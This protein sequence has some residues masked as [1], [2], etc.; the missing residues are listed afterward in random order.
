MHFPTPTWAT[1]RCRVLGP[2]QAFGSGAEPVGAECSGH[3]VCNDDG[4][5]V[6]ESTY[7]GLA[8]DKLIQALP[9]WMISRKQ[10]LLDLS[11]CLKGT[12][13][14]TIEVQCTDEYASTTGDEICTYNCP[15]L[16]AGDVDV[17]C[18]IFQAG[19]WH[20]TVDDTESIVAESS[21][22][23]ALSLNSATR[24]I[25]QGANAEAQCCHDHYQFDDPLTFLSED[26]ACAR[27]GQLSTSLA[28]TVTNDA[29]S[30]PVECDGSAATAECMSSYVCG[31][32]CATG[33]MV[34]PS[35]RLS[36]T[37][38]TVT[39][40]HLRF[41]DHNSDTTAS[42]AASFSLMES[43][44]NVEFGSFSRNTAGIYAEA[45]TVTVSFSTVDNGL[46]TGCC[47]TFGSAG[48]FATSHTTVHIDHSDFTN[49]EVRTCSADTTCAADPGEYVR[50][51]AL[52]CH[53]SAAVVTKSRFESNSGASAI[54][55]THQSELT[56]EYSTVSNNLVA[57]DGVHTGHC[58]G[59]VVSTGSVARI[60]F[61]MFHSNKGAVAGALFVHGTASMAF[62]E[63]SV[64][65]SNRA[66][67]SS[68]GSGAIASTSGGAVSVTSS[69]VDNNM[70]TTPVGAGAILAT[71]AAI[72]VTDSLLQNN[73]VQGNPDAISGSGGIYSDR[74]SIEVIR[75]KFVNNFGIR[76]GDVLAA[77]YSDALHSKSPEDVKVIDT[78]YDPFS[79]VESVIINPGS[80]NGRLRGACLDHPCHPGQECSYAD[81]S[82]SCAPCS[83]QTFSPDG[84][85]CIACD[86]GQG[87]SEDGT[88]C[89]PC[90]GDN[91]SA[92]GVCQPCSIQLVVSDD[93]RS[94]EECRVHQAATLVGDE[95][96]D[97]RKCGCETGFFNSST[98]NIACYYGGYDPDFASKTL[99]RQI[100]AAVST[101]QPCV[102]CVA[103][104]TGE[105][106]T[107]CQDGAD[108]AVRAGF[109]I[110]LLDDLST[111][112]QLSTSTTHEDGVTAIFR[113]HNDMELAAKRCPAGA[114][115]GTCALG[116]EG[117]MC[118]SCID[119]YGMNP[120]RECAPC[121][122]TGYTGQSMLVLLVVIVSVA[123]VGWLTGKIWSGF[124]LKHLA[125][126]A[127]QPARILITYSQ[128]TSQLGDVL[129]FQYPGIFGDVIGA[130]RPV[131]D[132]WGLLFRAL[133]PSECFGLK[134]FTA[135]W[136]L[137]VVGLPGMIALTII[138]MYCW[139]ARKH[140]AETAGTQ[141]KS[142]AFFGT[143]HRKHFP[144]L[145]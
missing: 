144:C 110:P 82:L 70:G 46:M 142:H 48:I 30:L 106:C 43:D 26:D 4:K 85:R 100:D 24:T 99:K 121:D 40:R 124:Q 33:G 65:H 83:R 51:T 58:A 71:D 137:R 81:F 120:S 3:G 123:A 21:V 47:S 92:F 109:T 2:G 18:Y 57:E 17:S 49:N 19:Q 87:P 6:C 141:A 64:F 118:D 61:A 80:Y 98:Q 10:A 115:P 130:L 94:C 107:S 131:M 105:P 8:C 39:L 42:D 29:A 38:A 31:F 53:E 16:S 36:L 113:C 27:G 41:E 28:T 135:R 23:N 44:V 77:D 13:V 127:F 56:L 138:S 22:F 132:L 104:A 126:C 68:A 114:A 14:G 60:K 91:A 111:R 63:H 15:S 75:S 25:I 7:T 101:G 122:G 145:H 69:T 35:A 1:R 79:D 117:Q 5:C 125:R 59:L 37:D 73:R 134:G 143:S 86:S 102:G 45:S 55:A 11:T 66:T 74:S 112:R 52:L 88:T 140:G 96:T 50:A 78:Q 12:S 95:S 97:L 93:H 128:I 90:A 32:P 20:A 54:T 103:D 133:G 116:Y 9:D 84:I 34:G 62:A 139:N 119:G 76:I 129:D 72:T 67:T 108:P 89:I 136:L